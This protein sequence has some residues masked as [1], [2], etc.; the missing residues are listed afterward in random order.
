MIREKDVSTIER[1][2]PFVT[3]FGGLEGEQVKILDPSFVKVF[4]ISQ[5]AVEYLLFCKKYLDNTVILLKK[6]L[7]NTAEESKEL[8]TA[9]HDLKSEANYLRK[10]LK[11]AESPRE[12]ATFRCEQCGKAFATEDYLAAHTKRRHDLSS[13]SASAYQDETNKLQLEIKELKERL[14]T[15]EKLITHH[16]RQTE[17]KGVDTARTQPDCSKLEELQA[18]FEVLKTHVEAELKLLHARKEFQEK[19]EKLFEATIANT[20]AAFAEAESLKGRSEGGEGDLLERKDSATQTHPE[21]QEV[22]VEVACEIEKGDADLQ[23]NLEKIQQELMAE[24]QQQISKAEG[25]LG[26]MVGFSAKQLLYS[27]RFSICLLRKI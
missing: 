10:K 3:Q 23:V 22:A 9:L 2:I 27:F 11:D 5:L 17:E 21:V 19:Y 15:T 13:S 6:E 26:E 20:K 14:N 25:F 12:V 8:K 7:S 16:E 24:T 4:R 18:K 1:F